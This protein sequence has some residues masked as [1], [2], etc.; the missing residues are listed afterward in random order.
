[1]ST[2]VSYDPE[3]SF[4]KVLVKDTGIGIKERD[5]PKLFKAFS[6]IHSSR[7]QNTGLGLSLHINKLICDQLGGEVI[8]NSIYGTG[9][10]FW[11]TF[12][13]TVALRAQKQYKK[14]LD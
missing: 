7:L 12:K 2:I 4:F 14:N 13:A 3:T 9:S 10:E 8:V 5:F 11:F 6:V 1:M